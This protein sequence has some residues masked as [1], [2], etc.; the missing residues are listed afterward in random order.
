VNGYLAS[1]RE[2]WVDRLEDLINDNDLRTRMGTAARRTIEEKWSVIAW[3]DRYL[4]L[5]NKLIAENK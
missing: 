5:F 1:S 3:R 4:E 2:E